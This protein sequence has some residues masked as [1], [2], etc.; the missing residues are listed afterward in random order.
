MPA[1]DTDTLSTGQIAERAGVNVQTVRYYERRGLL[2]EP[3]RSSQGYRQYRPRHAER[4]RFIKRAQDLGFTLDETNE[5]L[6]LSLTP[7]ADRA[8][9]RAQAKE[10]IE[11]VRERI[12]DL[13]R[14][15]ET[16]E[17]LVEA[18]EGHG[19]TSD[20]PIIGALESANEEEKTEERAPA[21]E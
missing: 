1:Q 4:I 18:C 3:P 2:P 7:G 17:M 12:R 9:V 16:L 15:E 19:S 10:K 6:R 5:L 13:R 21:A 8:D 20:C 11:E 14:I